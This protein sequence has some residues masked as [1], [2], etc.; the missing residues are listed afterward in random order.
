MAPSQAALKTASAQTPGWRRWLPPLLWVTALFVLSTSI[1]SAA[2]TSKI[3]EPVLRFLM[4]WASGLA[5]STM[6]ALIRKL[7][8]FTNYGVLFWLLI[9]GPMAGRPYAALALCVAYAMIDESHQLLAPGR[10]PS[11]YDVAIDSSGA[12]F[13]RFL[14]AAVSDLA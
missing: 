14:H 13:S 12:L 6:H 2:N 9:R 5:I 8:H 7:A 4:P 10:T 1:F 11:I 3:I